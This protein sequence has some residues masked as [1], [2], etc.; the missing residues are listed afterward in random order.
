MT[1]RLSPATQPLHA[2]LLR[3]R[4]R[5]ESKG[6]GGTLDDGRQHDIWE[7]GTVEPERHVGSL[8]EEASALLQYWGTVQTSYRSCQPACPAYARSSTHV[9]AGKLRVAYEQEGWMA[10]RC[11]R[12]IDPY[13]LRTKAMRIAVAIAIAVAVAIAIA[14]TQQQLRRSRSGDPVTQLLKPPSSTAERRLE[15]SSKIER[16]GL[17]SRNTLW[18]RWPVVSRHQSPIQ[19]AIPGLFHDCSEGFTQLPPAKW[20]G[21]CIVQYSTAVLLL[22][23]ADWG[24]GP[25]S[26]SVGIRFVF[27]VTPIRMAGRS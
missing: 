1:C 22:W 11:I 27:L 16:W 26:T 8:I 23:T 24:L 18:Q 12:A 6:W 13:D 21:P 15:Q 19:A 17:V 7:C 9:A 10:R 14:R 25:W 20:V 4:G 2:E 3:L 5:W